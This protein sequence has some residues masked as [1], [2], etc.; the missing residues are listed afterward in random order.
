[1]NKVVLICSQNNYNELGL[2]RSFGVNKIK[3]YGIIICKKKNW[4]KEWVHRSKYWKKHYRVDSAEKALDLLLKEF[5]NE[6]A[7]PVV[8]TPIDYVVQI[9]DARYDEFSK[10]FILQSIKGK[11]NGINTLANKLE[12]A[13]LTEFL[14]FKTLPT[15]ILDVENF[16]QTQVKDEEF[17][18]LLKPVQ[19]G[20]G[21]KDDITICRDRKELRDCIDFL[22][23]KNYQRILCQ[24]YLE[25]REEF[26][27]YGAV[28]TGLCSYTVIRNLRQ[29]PL[30]YG[31]GSFAKLVIDEKYIVFGAQLF[32]KLAEF[33]YN[34][35][36]DVEF[37][38][39][40]KTGSIYVSEYNWRPGGRNFTS[41]GTNVY[42][43]VLWYLIRTGQSIDGLT[44]V[45][46]KD[47]Y[48][49][50]DATDYNHV[51]Y[52][53]ITKRQ[54]RRDFK[55]SCAHAL[56]NKKDIKPWIIPTLSRIKNKILRKK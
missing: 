5:G 48:S 1:M 27:L 16:E 55:N 29:W 22:K 41:L 56:Y 28:C 15:K 17:P 44:V 30:S 31:V 49:M 19:G 20:E 32:K 13:K 6:K 53:N 21:A 7:K 39:D 9:I 52:K 33:G 8:I 14:G 4:K 47:G 11:Q 40:K 12:Q 46:R 37:F 38:L 24:K 51:I 43:I 10:K 36:I 42:S 54:W 26:V 2:V 35:P 23:G 3:P 50:N 45:N 25:E 18:L 34:G